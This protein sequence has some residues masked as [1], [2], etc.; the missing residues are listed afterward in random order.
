[1]TIN[2]LYSWGEKNNCLDVPLSKNSN[3]DVVD[4]ETAIHLQSEIHCLDSM[5]RVILD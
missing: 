4:I 3:L 2:E 1:M 5:D